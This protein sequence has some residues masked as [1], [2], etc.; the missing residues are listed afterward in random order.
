MAPFRVIAEQ[1]KRILRV[2]VESAILLPAFPA[3]STRCRAGLLSYGPVDTFRVPRSECPW[4][5]SGQVSFV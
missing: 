4:V 5:Y 3:E 2:G 1:M